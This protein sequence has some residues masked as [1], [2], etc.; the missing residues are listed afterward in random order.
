MKVILTQDVKGQ[1]KKDQMVDVSDGYARN[2]LFPRKLAKPADNQAVT[3]LKN[4]EAAR[5]HKIDTDRAAAKE[6][7][8][9]LTAVL[10]KFRVGAGADGHLYGSVTTKDI[11]ERLQKDHNIIVDKKKISP[12]DPLKAYGKY[13]LDVKLYTDVSGKINVIV[14]DQ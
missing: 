2:F 7:A 6:V 4:K 8:E 3:E 11:A 10:L 12:S 5:Q 9:K 14:T 13:E 1:G